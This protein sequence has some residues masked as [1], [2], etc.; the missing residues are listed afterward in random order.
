M[1]KLGRVQKLVCKNDKGGCSEE[2]YLKDGDDHV[3][4]AQVCMTPTLVLPGLAGFK[5][6]EVA[7]L[8][9]QPQPLLHTA[10]ILILID[11]RSITVRAQGRQVWQLLM[12]G[13]AV[14]GTAS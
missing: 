4:P 13:M 8:S 9:C 7:M 3:F 12:C 2:G 5:A 10:C 14:G 1:Q 11:H 6:Q